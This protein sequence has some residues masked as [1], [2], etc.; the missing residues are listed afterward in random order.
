MQK[1]SVRFNESGSLPLV[2]VIVNATREADRSLRLRE[3]P[4]AKQARSKN[5]CVQHLDF[6]RAG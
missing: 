5:I 3:I 6:F 2:R 1:G 4:R